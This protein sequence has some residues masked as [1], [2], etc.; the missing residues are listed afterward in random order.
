M[1]RA[2]GLFAFLAAVLCA[3]L[4]EAVSTRQLQAVDAVTQTSISYNRSVTGGDPL[5]KLQFN[6]TRLADTSGGLDPSQVSLPA[7]FIVQSCL[8]IATASKR[9][10][11]CNYMTLLKGFKVH[12]HALRRVGITSAFATALLT[13]LAPAQIHLTYNGGTNVTVSWATGQGIVTASPVPSYAADQAG[14]G[15]MVWYGTV[16]GN[17]TTNVTSTTITSYTQV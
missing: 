17:Y 1:A 15:N 2:Q 14:P 4:S 3:G 7:A 11:S 6:D 12:E 9:G 16:S 8:R 13:R 5:G 10:C